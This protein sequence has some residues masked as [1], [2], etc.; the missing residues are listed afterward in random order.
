[1]AT[2]LA[3]LALL[4]L[5]ALCSAAGAAPQRFLLASPNAA[6]DTL[7]PSAAGLARLAAYDQVR[8]V[9]LGICVALLLCGWAKP[10]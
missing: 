3:L 5:S 8:D 7:L 4:A 9:A 1:M 2:R 6:R 10:F